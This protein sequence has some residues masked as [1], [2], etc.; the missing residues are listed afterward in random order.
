MMMMMTMRASMFRGSI[1]QKI[2]FIT[3]TCIFLEPSHNINMTSI[4][5]KPPKISTDSKLITISID[6]EGDFDNQNVQSAM[7]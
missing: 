7:G 3:K 4:Q 2:G 1:S 5:S 6:F